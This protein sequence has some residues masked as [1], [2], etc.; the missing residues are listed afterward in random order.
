MRTSRWIRVVV[1][2]IIGA[3]AA[4]LVLREITEGPTPEAE[5]RK[6]LAD[7]RLA[8]A[9]TVENCRSQRD[10][11]GSVFDVF[12]CTIVA[13]HR[14]RLGNAAYLER[15]RSVVCFSVPRAGGHIWG[16]NYDAQYFRQ[17]AT[18]SGHPCFA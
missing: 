17:A 2:L 9:V 16:S 8:E 15:G 7:H 1:T 11:E 6:Y 10:S 5:V 4:V 13:K 12:A 18:G 14:A 3:A